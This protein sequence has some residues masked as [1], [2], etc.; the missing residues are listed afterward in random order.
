M[1]AVQLWWL[2]RTHTK[3]DRAASARFTSLLA[4]IA[5]AA[6]STVALVVVGGLLAFVRRWQEGLTVGDTPP[7]VYVMLAGF[8]VLL[9]IVPLATL[10]AAAARLAMARRDARLAALRLAGATASQVSVITLLDAGAQAAVGSLIGVAG[11]LSVLPV[12]TTL[13]FQGRQ[14]NLLEL[15]V[16][17]PILAAT[18]LGVI[19]VGVVSAASSLQRV[20]VTPLGVAARTTRPKLSIGRLAALVLA[21]VAAAVSVNLTGS[22]AGIFVVLVFGGFVAIAMAVLN[23]VG[24]LVLQVIGRI[25]AASARSAATLLAGRRIVDDPKAAWRSVGGVSIATFIAG[26][27]SVVGA[28]G[29]V[30]AVNQGERI[31]L[32]DLTTGGLLT[33]MIAGL[34]AAVSTGV[35]QAG[36]L[37]DQ[38]QEHRNLV[39][40]GTDT[41]TLARA[42]LRETSIPLVAALGTATAAVLAIMVPVVGPNIYAVPE[43][44]GLFLASVL[45]TASLVLA[46][47]WAAGSVA[48]GLT[49][50][51]VART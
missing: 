23:L 30:G 5:F 12:V 38:R 9:L 35:M 46:G 25:T 43:V 44:A 10:G 36:R 48:R 31:F 24:P 32:A 40:A 39:L 1:N 3:D 28:F 26:L 2:L 22:F 45:V 15:W 7:L 49:A 18:V 42:R 51:L 17:L 47:A 14:L 41:T 21:V 16:G 11:Y 33:L 29:G 13:S 4:V 20:S 34:L 27:T 37:I 50:D 6:T 19:A 8:A